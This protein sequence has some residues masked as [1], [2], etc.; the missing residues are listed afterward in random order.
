MVARFVRDEEAA[1][2]NPVIPTNK[3]SVT[4]RFLRF[5]L[6]LK[7]CKK[8]ILTT[9]FYLQLWDKVLFFVFTISK[10]NTPKSCGTD[11]YVRAVYVLLCHS[12]LRFLFSDFGFHLLYQY[13]EL[14]LTFFSCRCI[15][16]SCH[17]FAVGI[18]WRVSTFV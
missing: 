8:L 7:F 6:C 2:S 9:I 11:F 12:K 14:F 10:F 13:G 1:G 5:L 15:Y 18:L 4:R 3:T 16:V 17:S